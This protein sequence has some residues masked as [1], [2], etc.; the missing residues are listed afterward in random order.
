MREM[1][2]APTSIN[3]DPVFVIERAPNENLKLDFV[4]GYRWTIKDS[5]KHTKDGRALFSTACLMD[6]PTIGFRRRWALAHCRVCHRSPAAI[7]H[8]SPAAITHQCPA[9]I[10]HRSPA[11]ITDR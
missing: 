10:I 11:A 1:N 8:R 4:H 7:T 9:A 5:L 3:G 6:G 2:E